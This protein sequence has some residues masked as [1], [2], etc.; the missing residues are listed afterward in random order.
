MITG[1]Y[2]IPSRE[3]NAG[4]VEAPVTGHR[5]VMLQLASATTLL[6]V[7]V[8]TIVYA[9]RQSRAKYPPGPKPEIFLGNARQVPRSMQWLKFAEWSKLYG[10]SAIH[11]H[12]RV[13]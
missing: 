11:W 7:A 8:A 12:A 9:G 10:T 2:H 5:S 3:S 4:R 6:A 13:G 1:L